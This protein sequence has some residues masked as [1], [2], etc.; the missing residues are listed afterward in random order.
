MRARDLDR[1]IRAHD[2]H[3]L[4]AGAAICP[5]REAQVLRQAMVDAHERLVRHGQRTNRRARR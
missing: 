2:E 5:C 3:V 4:H 1:R